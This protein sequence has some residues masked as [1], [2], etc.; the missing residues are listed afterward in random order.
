MASNVPIKVIILL[1][2]L[3][4]VCI[5]CS[6]RSYN[7]PRRS[8]PVM[9]GVAEYPMHGPST[10]EH[11]LPPDL[12]QPYPGKNFGPMGPVDRKF[13][14]DA[15]LRNLESDDPDSVAIDPHAPAK[16]LR[17]YHVFTVEFHRVETPFVIGIWIF[18]A[19]LAKIGE[20]AAI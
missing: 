10:D 14:D 16:K 8:P 13:P 12:R 6:A 9:P 18:F 20:F 3:C 2:F 15:S 11:E 1:M 19:S 17:E 4:T 7:E 5:R